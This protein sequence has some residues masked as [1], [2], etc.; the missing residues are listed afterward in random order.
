MTDLPVRLNAAVR[1]FNDH[2]GHLPERYAPNH[3]R[4]REAVNYALLGSGK[5]IRPLLCHAAARALGST[6]DLWLQPALGL[7]LIHTYSLVHDD[8]PAMDNDAW[9]RGRPTAHIA[10][11]EATAILVGDALQA[12]AFQ[13]LTEADSQLST[14]EQQLHWVRL[15]SS[16]AGG[17]GMVDGQ[18]MDCAATGGHSSLEALETMHR[19]KTGAL[20]RAAVA[21]GAWCSEQPP[22]DTELQALD[23]YGAAI[24]LAFQVVDDVLDATSNTETLGKDA[25]SDAARDKVTYVTLLGIEP[26]R[27]KAAQLEREALTALQALPGDTTLLA[28]IAHFIVARLR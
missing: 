25:G 19:N 12:L 4:L 18:A 27:H 23:T 22:A 14:S 9:R 20:I 26:A 3:P 11:D 24:G 21:M 6:G 2:L 16:A 8:L 15:L 28:E 1:Q 13:V 7:E 10:F 5:R 17:Q